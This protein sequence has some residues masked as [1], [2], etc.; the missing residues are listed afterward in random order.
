M[1]S[2]HHIINGLFTGVFIVMYMLYP[3]IDL[4]S[5][6]CVCMAF[7]VYIILCMCVYVCLPI[8]CEFMCT[9]AM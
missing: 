2:L 5:V 9:C 3:C 1:Y 7:C 4:V 6:L 8:V